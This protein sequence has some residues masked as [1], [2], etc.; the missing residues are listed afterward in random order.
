M[1]HLL[2]KLLDPCTLVNT[3]EHDKWFSVTCL[4]LFFSLILEETL[5]LLG[6]DVPSNIG[7]LCIEVLV[8]IYIGVPLRNTNEAA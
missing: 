8:H 6:R 4:S 2:L 5:Y 1:K 7:L 3:N